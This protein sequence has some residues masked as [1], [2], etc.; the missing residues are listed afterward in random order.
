MSKPVLGSA[1]S[2]I[3]QIP[4]S[5]SPEVRRP[6]RKGDHSSPSIFFYI[7]SLILSKIPAYFGFKLTLYYCNVIFI[8]CKWV[9]TRWQWF[10]IRH[11]KQITH[12][13]QIN[14]TIKGNTAHKTTH[15]IKNTLHRMSTNNV[16]SKLRTSGA[17]LPISH[18]IIA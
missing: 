10:T 6:E 15:T 7:P 14:T 16:L 9:F 11:N 13:T 8:N 12:I 18:V 1:Q 5:I 3:Q 2:S 4:R 17:I